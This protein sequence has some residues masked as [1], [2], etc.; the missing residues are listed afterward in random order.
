MGIF[1]KRS[2]HQRNTFRGILTGSSKVRDMTISTSTFQF[3]CRYMQSEP[4][5]QF[6]NMSR[7]HVDLWSSDLKWFP[8]FLES[9]PKLKSLIAVCNDGYEKPNKISFSSVPVCMLSSL[10]FVDFKGS[11]QGCAAEMKLVRYFL[12]NSAGLK[13]LTL[14]VGSFSTKDDILK[15]LLKITTKCEVVIL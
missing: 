9:F 15:K 6:V 10:E 13:K 14:R 5:P 11:F 2:L 1:T 12:K 3:I 8:T 4:L 7:L